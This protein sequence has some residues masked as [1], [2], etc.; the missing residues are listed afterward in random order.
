LILNSIDAM[1]TVNEQDRKLEI[2]ARPDTEG[3][4]PVVRIDVTD[5]GVGFAGMET[6]RLFEL[7]YTT[8]PSG[9]GIGLAISRTIVEAHR[10]RLSA[11][12]NRGRGATFS[13]ILP[14]EEA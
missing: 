6:S 8:K 4:R 14:A 2:R 11:E 10:G 5:R 9:M 7:F 3:G 1:A 12:P 13:I